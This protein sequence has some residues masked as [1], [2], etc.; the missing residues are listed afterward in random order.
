LFEDNHDRPSIPTTK[1]PPAVP[2]VINVPEMNP[3]FDVAADLISHSLINAPIVDHPHEE[4][5]QISEITYA[6]SGFVPYPYSVQFAAFSN[7]SSTVIPMPYHLQ[8]AQQ[9]HCLFG[10]NPYPKSMQSLN[11]FGRRCNTLTLVIDLLPDPLPLSTPADD[12]SPPLMPTISKKSLE[13]HLSTITRSLI[14]SIIQLIHVHLTSAYSL[15][16]TKPELLWSNIP[17]YSVTPTEHNSLTS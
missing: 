9:D 17:I 10:E 16:P 8:T 15:N 11:I 3:I 14:A 1:T 4:I 5:S 7:S 2:D 6:Q 12:D 13:L